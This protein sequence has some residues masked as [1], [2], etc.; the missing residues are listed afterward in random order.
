MPAEVSCFGIRHHGPGSARRL[1]EALEALSPAEV[2][3]EGP[4]D[5]SDL[6]PMLASALMMPP[7]ALLAYAADAPEKAIFWPMAAF[8]P[9]YQAV[10]WA[11][12]A[13]V[14]VRFIDLPASW[15]L[16]VHETE[17]GMVED[18]TPD[19]LPD[20]PDDIAGRDDGATAPADD[21]ASAILVER[22]H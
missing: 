11:E 9:E 17:D 1:V 8:S 7:V 2:L 18:G 10:L 3:I 13:G 15:R 21:R 20:A 12:R 19:A 5:L 16:A 14:P 6:L 22:P 4:S